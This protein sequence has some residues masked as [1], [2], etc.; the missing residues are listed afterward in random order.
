MIKTK[1][2]TKK[3]CPWQVFKLANLQLTFYTEDKEFTEA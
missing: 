3:Y 2:Q 1:K